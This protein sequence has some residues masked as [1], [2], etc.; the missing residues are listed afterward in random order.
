MFFHQQV[1]WGKSEGFALHET[2]PR[3]VLIS[4]V[5]TEVC[6][7]KDYKLGYIFAQGMYC[8]GG[9]GAGPC[10]GDSGKQR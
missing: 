9:D 2:V 3:Q 8:A 1:G 5:T 4:S 10:T 7:A 6:F